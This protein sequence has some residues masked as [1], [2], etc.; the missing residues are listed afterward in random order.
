MTDSIV[1]PHRLQVLGQALK[2]VW[3]NLKAHLE[4]PSVTNVP[5]HGIIDVVSDHL[6]YLQGAVSPLA[7]RIDDLMSDV[8]SNPCLST[9]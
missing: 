1:V 9:I 6:S 7:R 4:R 5:V 2:P 8:V 3:M